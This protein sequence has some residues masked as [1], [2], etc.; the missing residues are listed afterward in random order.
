MP[1]PTNDSFVD[2][3]P[4]SVTRSTD[5]TRVQIATRNVDPRRESSSMHTFV[6]LSTRGLDWQLD[7]AQRAVS[8]A[9]GPWK[10]PVRPA[11]PQSSGK[12]AAVLPC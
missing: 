9:A 7:A 4:Q 11:P 1:G 10:T 12:Q 3:R 6:V 8:A 2:M 5:P